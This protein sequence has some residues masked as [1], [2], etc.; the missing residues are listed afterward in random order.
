MLS[1][2]VGMVII[3]GSICF[4]LSL[5]FKITYSLYRR[6]KFINSP[7]F[8]TMSDSMSKAEK[9]SFTYQG[10]SKLAGIL[11]FVFLGTLL[12]NAKT[13]IVLVALALLIFVLYYNSRVLNEL[14]KYE[15]V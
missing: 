9:L 1:F 4:I 5:I 7:E 6:Y 15:S 3:L 8:K 10:M 2:I 11:F 14:K 12:I 13:W